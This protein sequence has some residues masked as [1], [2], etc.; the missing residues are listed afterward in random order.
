MDMRPTTDDELL[1]YPTVFFSSDE[2]SDPSTLDDE[3]KVKDIECDADDEL[4]DFGYNL[5]GDL[6]SFFVGR[7]TILSTGRNLCLLGIM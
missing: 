3:H 2:P 7:P 4:P 6:G 1:A 5:V